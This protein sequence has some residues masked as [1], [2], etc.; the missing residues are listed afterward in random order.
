MVVPIFKKGDRQNVGNYRPVSL[1]SSI[2]RI[3]ESVLS[4]KLTTYVLN[5]NIIS[6]FQFGFLPKKSSCSNLL[7]SLYSWLKSYS[8]SSCTS[9]LYTDFK[10]AFDSVNHRFLIHVLHSSG[11]NS[12][13]VNWL[14]NFL[15]DRQQIVCIN[16][17]MSTP[18]TV[19][20]GVPQGSVI[21]PFLFLLFINGITDPSLLSPS[22]SIRLFADDSKL[23]STD[24]H[25]LQIAINKTNSWLSQRQLLLAP[26]KCVVL[27]LKRPSSTD[28]S[29]FFIDNHPVEEVSNMKDL[30]VI[31]SSDLKWSTHIDSICH[32]A[33]TTSFQL[34]KIIKSA[35]IWTWLRIFKTY[36]RPKLE[37]N[38]P[39][40]PPYMLKDIKRVE[41]VQKRF[42][43]IA[44]QKCNIPFSS[45][46][47]RL[48]KVNCLSLELRRV[49]FD[50]VLM[51]KIIHNLSDL[52]FDDFFLFI[53]SSYSLRSH[54]FQIKTFVKFQTQG[55]HSFFGR[56]PSLWNKLPAHVVD[57]P[58]LATFKSSVKRHLLQSF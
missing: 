40:W 49:Y 46:K 23:F 58:S 39:V 19:L 4:E 44:F 51:F 11:L 13:V 35:N 53:N 43:K 42:T 17:S 57:S 38:T 30:G 2:S 14:K 10:K 5:H 28:T 3:F 24:P 37:Y 21:G 25:D 26:H 9:V 47:D 15:T 16:N 29:Q 31:I 27:K 22:V 12:Q 33:S 48:Y 50:V 32:S 54:S 56:I 41:S 45:Y 20:S 6:S 8:L 55:F 1:T 18:L 52:K 36:I 7:S 34:I